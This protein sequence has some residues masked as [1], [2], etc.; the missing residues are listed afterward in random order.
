[1]LTRWTSQLLGLCEEVNEIFQ[2]LVA[3][4]VKVGVRVIALAGVLI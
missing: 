2:P 1:M 3:H 4:A